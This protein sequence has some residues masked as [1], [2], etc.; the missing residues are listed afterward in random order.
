MTTRESMAP[1]T[2][3]AER[4]ALEELVRRLA[5]VDDGIVRL[6]RREIVARLREIV[7]EQQRRH[8]RVLLDGAPGQSFLL[9]VRRYYGALGRFGRA[10]DDIEITSP[11]HVGYEGLVAEARAALVDLF[12]TAIA[13]LAKLAADRRAPALEPLR[14]TTADLGDTLP[15][16]LPRA[17]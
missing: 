2:F 1:A 16:E 12:E 8:E 14:A 9:Y 17:A 3:L 10:L 13:P 7:E 11:R 5:L 15:L 6:S 4:T